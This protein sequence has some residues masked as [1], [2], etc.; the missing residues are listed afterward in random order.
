MAKL[1]PLPRLK[2]KK[3]KSLSWY[4]KNLW[5]IF[6]LYIRKRDCDENGYGPCISC[7]I[8]KH[9]KEMNA[10]HYHPQSLGLQTVF[11]EKNVHLQCTW[12][13]HALQSNQV[14]YAKALVKRYGEGILEELEPLKHGSLKLYKS[15]YEEM[16]EKYQK[17]IKGE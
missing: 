5:T 7:G 15:D 4:R 8:V 17:L 10:G 9:Y 12:C 14:E 6:S 2:K 3:S 13:N 1:P 16:I 11:V